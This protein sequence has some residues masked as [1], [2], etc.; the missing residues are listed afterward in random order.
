MELTIDYL[1]EKGFTTNH[2]ERVLA[3]YF[4]SG[5]TPTQWRINVE[6]NYLPQSNQL[7]FDVFCWTTNESGQIIKRSSVSHINTVEDLNAIIE[8]CNI[9][10]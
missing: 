10:F 4:K 6:Q 9:S 1:K 2:P 8:I 3:K 5:N 7:M